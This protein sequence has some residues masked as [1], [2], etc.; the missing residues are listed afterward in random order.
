M[1]TPVRIASWDES[2]ATLVDVASGRKPA[3]IVVRNGRWV[4]VYSGEIIAGTDIAIV[5]GRFAYV[6][7]SAQ[8]A[9]G[10]DTKVIEANGR[11]LVP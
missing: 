1:T 2:A 7:P 10:P 4:N 3:D 5:A 11:Y 9:I 6:G 8:H